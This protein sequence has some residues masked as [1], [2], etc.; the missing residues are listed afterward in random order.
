MKTTKII[1]LTTMVVGAL[2]LSGCSDQDLRDLADI[3]RMWGQSHGLLDDG[4]NPDYWN[5]GQRTLGG[6]TGDE[7]ADAVVDAGVVVDNFASAEA[8]RDAAVKAKDVKKLDSAI[9]MR[10]KEFRY[11]NDKGALLYEQGKLDAAQDEWERAA[12]IA[13]PYGTASQIRN[14]QSRIAAMWQVAPPRQNSRHLAEL[15]LS[16]YEEKYKL[17]KDPKDWDTIMTIQEGL[18]KGYFDE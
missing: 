7:Q 10:P 18:I 1:L 6:S 4:G 9:A 2:L 3:A 11:H 16:S 15:K 14:L 13:K 12:A 5:I 8:V 17:T